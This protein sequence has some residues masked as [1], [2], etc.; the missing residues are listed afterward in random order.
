MHYGMSL[1]AR[2]TG[3]LIDVLHFVRIA[4]LPY[5]CLG[6]KRNA[7][8]LHI[9]WNTITMSSLLDVARRGS[10]SLITILTL[11][12]GTLSGMLNLTILA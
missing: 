9:S 12:F 7:G 3:R 5:A 6:T 1:F 2:G 10:G 4:L 8:L 11:P